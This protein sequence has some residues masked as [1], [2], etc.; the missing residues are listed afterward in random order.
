MLIVV[1]LQEEQTLEKIS[2]LII[3]LEFNFIFDAR[4][5]FRNYK[6]KVFV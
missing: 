6:T 2:K 4:L 5:E 1:L 3:F